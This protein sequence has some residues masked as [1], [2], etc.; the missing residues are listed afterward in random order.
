MVYDL[1]L[2]QL[3]SAGRWK[4]SDGLHLRRIFGG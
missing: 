2:S 1:I 3:K 4:S